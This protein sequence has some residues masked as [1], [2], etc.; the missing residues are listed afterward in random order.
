MA[1]KL[2]PPVAAGLIC[3]KVAPKSLDPITCVPLL[4]MTYFP[5]PL[6]TGVIQKAMSVPL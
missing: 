3:E 6:T 1:V 5:D 2:H 4:N